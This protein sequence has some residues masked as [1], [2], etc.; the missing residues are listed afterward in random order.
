MALA[1]VRIVGFASLADGDYVDILYVHKDFQ[2]QG[3]A[4]KLLSELERKAKTLEVDLIRSDV[5]ITARPFFEHKGYV[6]LR[7]NINHIKG[8]NLINYKMTKKL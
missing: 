5:S 6:L 8:V 4:S 7:V 1:G 3:I 2:K